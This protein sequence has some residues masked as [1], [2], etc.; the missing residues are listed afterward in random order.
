MATANLYRAAGRPAVQAALLTAGVFAVYAAGACRT[1]YVGDS[2]ELV[3][4]AATLG[5]PHPSGYPLY[6]LLGR[7][8]IA[9]VPVVSAAYAMSLFSAAFAGLTCGQLYL[10]VRR[11]GL[12]SGAALL[13]ALTLAFCPSFWSQAGVQRV[14]SLNA[15]FVV[16]VCACALDWHRSRRLSS[17][18]LAA[19]LAGLGAANHTVMGVIGIAIGVFALVSEPR[20]MLRPRHLLACIGAGVCGLSPYAYLPLRSRQEP[21]LDWG[22]PET[23]DGFLGVMLRRDFWHRAWIE[24]PGDSLLI[25]GD[26]LRGLG[27]ELLWAGAALALAGVVWGRRR[28][29][30]L[31]PLSVMA[32]N[33]WAVGVHGSRTDIF[34]WHRYYI[35]SYVMASLLA[36]WGMELALERW[37]RRAL[38]A[39]A[40]P[41]LLLILG[42]PRFDRGDYRVADDF[43]RQLLA[44]LPPGAHLAASDDNI[45]FV[46]IY[47]HLVEGLRPDVDLIMQGVGDADLGQLRFDPDDDPLFFT[48]HPN[49][50]LPEIEVV[51]VG[52]VFRTVRA[53]TRPKLAL[54]AGELAGAGEVMPGDYLTQ[55]LIG[56]Y[57]YMMGIT[58]ETRDWPRAGA[59]FERAAAAASSNDVLFYNLGLIYRRN[60]LMRRALETFER[61]AEINPRHIPSGNPVRALDRVV[62]VRPEVERL[63]ALTAELR[64]AA[65]LTTAGGAYHRAM[66]EMLAQRGEELAARG[67]RL[68]ALEADS[69][70][71]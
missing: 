69:S 23:L 54:P 4:A 21:R 7:L 62:E 38:T 3:T 6:V 57:H 48:H 31:L 56:H 18:V 15:F 32:A 64:L 36:A 50:N 45:L 30:V 14:Y 46:L 17:L 65:G 43:S 59:A 60:G 25:L 24:S 11:Q 26:Y 52:L 41:G 5:I 63:E 68:L 29:P 42:W 44:T 40:V 28:F 58:F 39:L 66:A 53:G 27:T 67:H 2:G 34:I 33:L 16:A 20:L 35:P 51:P 49:W 13:A 55:N 1:I 47:L 8:W 10:L 22:D 70:A 19:L 37:G 9:L 71:R 61:S 12:S